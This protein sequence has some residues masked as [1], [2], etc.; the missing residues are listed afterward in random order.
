MKPSV[1]F[2]DPAALHWLA[3]QGARLDAKVLL[4]SA[5]SLSPELRAQFTT[6]IIDYYASTRKGPK[7]L[8]LPDYQL[9]VARG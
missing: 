8:R 9:G 7:Y 6:P 2:S 4:S 1:I 5:Q 3:S